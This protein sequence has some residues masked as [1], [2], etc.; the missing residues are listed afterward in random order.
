MLVG[1]ALIE[2]VQANE[3]LNQTELARTAGYVR[4]T[5]SGREQVLVKDFY[6]ALLAAKGLAIAVGKAPGKPALFETTVHK[7]GIILLGKTYSR[8][9]GLN[10]GDVLEIVMEDDAIQLIP[11]PVKTVSKAKG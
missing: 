11:R 7:S 6:N 8:K 5:R 2:H 1:Q 4:V 3:L 9:F 10:P